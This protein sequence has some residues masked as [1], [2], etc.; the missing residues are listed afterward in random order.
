MKK[1]E[2]DKEKVR[3]EERRK[4]EA[5]EMKEREIELKRTQRRMIYLLNQIMTQSENK[6]FL[7]F[8][9]M[10]PLNPKEY[11]APNTKRK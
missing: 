3:V 4:L 11:P 10:C 9:R 2:D 5:K 8:Q 1:L 7:D 6:Q